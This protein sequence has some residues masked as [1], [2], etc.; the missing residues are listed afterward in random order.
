MN[1]PFRSTDGGL[2]L[3]LQ[4]EERAALASVHTLLTIG[5]DAGGRLSYS[6]HP[7]DPDAEERYRSL[8]GDELDRLRDDDRAVFEEVRT[9]EVVQPESIEAFMRVV[10]EARI[11]LASR[12]GFEEDGWESAAETT[13][14]EVALLMWLGYLQDA[15]VQVLTDEG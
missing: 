7:D 15:A 14:P 4:P 9:G 12:L 1:G 5:G 10:G 6:A 3:R 8:V 2:V 11:V 13:D